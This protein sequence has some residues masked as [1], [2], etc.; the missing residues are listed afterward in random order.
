MPNGFKKSLCIVRTLTRRNAFLTYSTDATTFVGTFV[1]PFASHFQHFPGVCLAGISGCCI[2]VNV[3]V[4]GTPYTNFA[5]FFGMIE[6]DGPIFKWCYTHC[7]RNIG[8]HCINRHIDIDNCFGNEVLQFT[9][10]LDVGVGGLGDGGGDWGGGGR[11][12]V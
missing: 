10:G 2:P 3:A 11:R 1:L 5:T 9:G 6:T 4:F 12:F 8:Q 7:T